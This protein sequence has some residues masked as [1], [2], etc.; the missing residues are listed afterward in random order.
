MKSSALS[1][2]CSEYTTLPPRLTGTAITA[3][4]VL[5][6]APT[7]TSDT[8]G[9][10]LSN[11]RCTRSWFEVPGTVAPA[12]SELNS[13]RLPSGRTSVMIVPPSS[14]DSLTISSWKPARSPARS[15]SDRAS[16]SSISRRTR[17]CSS[18]AT[19]SA[20]VVERIEVLSVSRWLCELS[21]DR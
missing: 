6:T 18:T 16:A 8:C 10:P 20:R 9:C 2:S 7:K 4:G 13:A 14:C 12:G 21:Y 1:V 5:V 11:T 19:A 3:S 17:M 15:A